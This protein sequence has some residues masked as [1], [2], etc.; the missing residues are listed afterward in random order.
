[1]RFTP[2]ALDGA[3]VIDIEPA[4][5]ERGF[6]ARTYCENEFAA[7]GLPTSWVQSNVSFNTARHTLRGMHYQRPPHGE[8]KLVRATAGAIHDVIVDLRPDSPTYMSYE[9]FELSAE[10]RRALY[11]PPGFAHGFITMTEGAEVFYMMGAFYVPGSAAGVRYD[12]PAFG[13]VWP[14]EPAVISERDLA[15]EA[16]AP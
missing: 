1:M 8:P 15:Y 6:F 3:W 9:G 12:D 13:I 10:N 16:F 4:A 2:S 7:H 5:D 14:A 11:I